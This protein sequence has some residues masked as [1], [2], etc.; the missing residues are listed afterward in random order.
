L[1]L[2]VSG[3]ADSVALLHLVAK[4]IP[5][6]ATRVKIV[7]VHHGLRDKA[8]DRDL[9][10]VIKHAQKLKLPYLVYYSDV[11]KIAKQKGISVEAA[12]RL[13]RHDCF[14]DAVLRN[15]AIAVLLAHHQD[16]QIE[17][18]L[19]HLL[20]GAG[21]AGLSA[22]QADRSFPHPDAPKSLRLIRPLLEIPKQELEAYLRKNKIVWHQDQSNLDM[23]FTRNKIRHQLLPML[24]KEYS[25]QIRTRLTQSLEILA[26]E[27]EYFN[28][29]TQRVMKT[30]GLSINRER[31]FG[32]EAP[33]SEGGGQQNASA[34]A[35]GGP[36][37]PLKAQLVQQQAAELKFNR[38]KYLRLP[39]AMQYRVL[40]Y[41]WE[42]M[43]IPQKST[44][45]LTRWCE[46][47]R[48][49]HEG[50]SLPGK[51]IA[52]TKRDMVFL[53]KQQV[54]NIDLG[55][56]FRVHMGKTENPDCPYGVE[57]K[58][59]SVPKHVR[60][61]S[62]V[63][64]DIVVAEEKLPKVLQLRTYRAGDWMRPLGMEKQKKQIKK[65]LSE[66]KLSESQRQTW[67]LLAKGPEVLWVFRG[68][69]SERIKIAV[70]TKKALKIRIF[71]PASA[72]KK[73]E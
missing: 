35:S 3:G 56:S 37:V 32:G 13:V 9:A 52:W 70:T 8:A 4:A 26:R 2:G 18:F 69:V 59:V 30:L 55:Y 15:K 20:R 1:V 54:K 28:A 65:I 64:A 72:T 21:P 73:E 46:A 50:L 12:G 40:S 67:P 41:V 61:K 10:L 57:M 16:D 25:P 39:K 5:Q 42:K 11:A 66:M 43:C 24:E 58:L 63:S 45:H 71:T 62:R 47:I 60:K 27:D 7:H 14:L 68:P 48:L 51:W 44:Q 22:M 17:T 49:G 33:E 29:Q 19:L 38:T 23:T 31:G 36:A 34:F 6:P 53:S